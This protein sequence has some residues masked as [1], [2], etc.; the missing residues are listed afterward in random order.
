MES[1]FFFALRWYNTFLLDKQVI[2]EAMQKE[3]DSLSISIL[4]I[5]GFETFKVSSF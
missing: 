2:N 3:K 4:D 5:S 1:F